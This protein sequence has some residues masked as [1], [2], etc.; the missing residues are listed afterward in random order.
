[1]NEKIKSYILCIAMIF[2]VV[3]LLGCH[4]EENE[5]VKIAEKNLTADLESDLQDGYLNYYKILNAESYTVAPEDIDDPDIA[6]QCKTANTHIIYE[7]RLGNNTGEIGLIQMERYSH[8]EKDENGNIT[9]IPEDTAYFDY[10][11]HEE[12]VGTYEATIAGLNSV[13]WS[14]DYQPC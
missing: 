10:D 1:M 13:V 12:K 11:L 4:S 3:T 7:L 5:N 6:M 9:E 8:V 2:A 14:N